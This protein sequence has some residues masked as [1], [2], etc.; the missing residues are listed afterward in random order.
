MMHCIIQSILYALQKCNIAQYT[1]H[2][3]H[4]SSDTL[5][6]YLLSSIAPKVKEFFQY[7]T[8]PK[9]KCHQISS[10]IIKCHIGNSFTNFQSKVF[11]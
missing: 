2:Y 7:Y 8:P 10:V 11:L 1:T 6:Q 3:Y 5:L 4:I 9:A